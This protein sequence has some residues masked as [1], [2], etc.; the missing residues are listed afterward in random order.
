MSSADKNLDLHENRN[1]QSIAGKKVGLVVSEWNSDVTDKL[2]EGCLEALKAHGLT[3]ND[4]Q[5][6]YVP[7]SYELSFGAQK[8]AQ[9]ESIDGVVVLGCII[10]GET[11]HFDFISSAVAHGITDVSLKYD[12][13]VI[14]GVLTPD[15]QEQ[16]L[17]R[18]GGKH[19]NKGYEAGITLV[20]MLNAFG[21]K[22]STRIGF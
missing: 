14:F 19:G 12:K 9:K 4:L 18:A 1:L 16:A 17:D 2:I 22:S 6:T 21:R 20:K 15:N 3:D 11:R 8:L 5:T 10:Q 13:P 7:G